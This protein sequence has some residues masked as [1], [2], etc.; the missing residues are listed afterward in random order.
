MDDRNHI[1]EKFCKPKSRQKLCF[2]CVSSEK[3]SV[4]G[5]RLKDKTV[6]SFLVAEV[7]AAG[8]TE[9]Q[10]GERSQR[11]SLLPFRWEGRTK[12]PERTIFCLHSL[13]LALG[14]NITTLNPLSF[15][16]LTITE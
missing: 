12:K 16:C 14:T 10:R 2:V 3:E 15:S 9:N 1:S 4:D 6:R 5:R 8:G 7:A 13:N 11:G